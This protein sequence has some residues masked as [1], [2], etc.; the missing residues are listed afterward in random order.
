M[1]CSEKNRRGQIWIETVIYTLIAFVLIAALLGVARPKIEQ[2]QDKTIIDQSLGIMKDMHKILSEI[3]D[4][5]SGNKR[6]I[7]VK[8]NRGSL[9]VQGENDTLFFEIESTY[10]YSEPGTEIEDGNIVVNTRKRGENYVTSL[11]ENYS[12]SYN[13]TYLDSDDSKTISTAA[14]TYT[15]FV[16]NNGKDPAGKT[17]INFELE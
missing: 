10:M 8:I 2:L 4:G 14:A 12:S 11:S 7:E 9:E 16:S 15:L 5:G 1:Y 17:I 3:S 6:V 13:I